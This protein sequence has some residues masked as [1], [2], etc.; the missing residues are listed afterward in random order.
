MNNQYTFPHKSKKSIIDFLLDHKGRHDAYGN[1]YPL[2]WDVKVY[3]FDIT[4]GRRLKHGEAI[5]P[6]L[7]EE[8]DHFW[9]SE[10][11][12]DLY[13]LIFENARR[14]YLEG[15]Y[16]TYPGDDQGN[17]KFTF[18]G[19]SGGWLALKEWLGFDFMRKIDSKSCW[20]EYLNYLF[21]SDLRTLYKAVRCMDV[22]FT[23]ENASK[24]VSY[25]LNFERTLWE[26][27][28]IE[29]NTKKTVLVI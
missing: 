12:H 14:P 1:Y 25:A 23:R 10:R 20:E 22:D 17:W 2:V 8:W 4:G 26:E 9:R 21:F 18:I 7:D 6:L 29:N 27:E 24:N 28:I 19:R 15:E 13:D 11:S 5:D 16:T 3:D